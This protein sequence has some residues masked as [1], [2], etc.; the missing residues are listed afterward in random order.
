MSSAVAPAAPAPSGVPR[1][2]VLAGAGVLAAGAASAGCGGPSADGGPGALA[3][4][5]VAAVRLRRRTARDSSA[6]LA[7]Y[8]AVAASH[9]ALDGTLR[10]LRA[11]VARHLDVLA[12]DIPDGSA[13]PVPPEPERALS[14]LA[15]SERRTA[16][17]RLR[18]LDGAP[19]ELARLLAS[20]AA[21]GSSHAYLLAEA[22]AG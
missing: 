12:E 2:T 9:P 18:A 15:D 19:P 21:A 17:T 13:G 20:L 4:D 22:R 7:S 8:D 11:A 1:R 6:L 10:P 14:W 5:D 3:E 16:G